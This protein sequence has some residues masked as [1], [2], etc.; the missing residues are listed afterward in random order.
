M[1]FDTEDLFL[2]NKSF[3]VQ[4]F[5]YHFI[6]YKFFKVV[7]LTIKSG[8]S[9]AFLSSIRNCASRI[10]SV[11]SF[12]IAFMDHIITSNYKIFHDNLKKSSYN[13]NSPSKHTVSCIVTRNAVKGGHRYV[14]QQKKLR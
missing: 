1:T 8:H 7:N 11:S 9:D 10:M 2:T 5:L 4:R 14:T 13:S 3:F 12:P 6:F